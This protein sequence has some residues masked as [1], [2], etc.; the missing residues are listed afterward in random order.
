MTEVL[1]RAKQNVNERMYERNKTPLQAKFDAMSP[2]Q[3]ENAQWLITSALDQQ[4]PYSLDKIKYDN[5]NIRTNWSEYDESWYEEV[6]DGIYNTAIVGTAN[7]LYNLIPTV[8]QAVGVESKFLEDWQNQGD[9]FFDSWNAT[10]SDTPGFGYHL[11]AGIGFLLPLFMS[12][13]SSAATGIGRFGMAGL[14]QS[15]KLG[16]VGRVAL[17][18]AR[19]NSFLTGTTLMY[20]DLR[21]EAV[22]AGM[23][24]NNASRLALFTSGIVSMTEGAALEWIGQSVSAPVMK[25]I[26]KDAMMSTIKTLGEKGVNAQT[27]K[28]YQR[29]IQ[30]GFLNGMKRAGGNIFKG[31]AIEF[32][33]E[34]SQ[35]YIEE[36][37]KRAYVDMN[38]ALGGDLEE[39]MMGEWKDFAGTEGW[40]MFKEAAYSGSIGAIIGGGMGFVGGIRNGDYKTQTAYGAVENNLNKPEKLEKMKNLIDKKVKDQTYTLEQGEKMKQ[41]LD[42]MR[43]VALQSKAIG[44]TDE[45]NVAK[46]QVYQ[47][48][49]INKD[50]RRDFKEREAQLKEVENPD[51]KAVE[52]YNRDLKQ[53]SQFQEIVAEDYGKIWEERKPATKSTAVFE[54]RMKRYSKIADMINNKEDYNSIQD[55][56]NKLKESKAEDLKAEAQEEVKTQEAKTTE[57]KSTETKPEEGK[58]Y[59]EIGKVDITHL[60]PK[61]QEG[62]NLTE[63]QLEADKL[64]LSKTENPERI[65]VLEKKIA[66]SEGVLKSFSEPK[67]ETQK[68]TKPSEETTKTTE[69]FAEQ[70]QPMEEGETEEGFN[71][72][73][74]IDPE[75]KQKLKDLGYTDQEI[76]SM[77]KGRLTDI[78]QNKE[79]AKSWRKRNAIDKSEKLEKEDNGDVNYYQDKNI[80]YT[81]KSDGTILRN[82]KVESDNTI[83]GATAKVTIEKE[84][85]TVEEKTIDGV[86]YV[87][88]E[89]G[90]VYV[91]HKP[92]K[93]KKETKKAIISQFETKGGRTESTVEYGESQPS[94]PSS[95]IDTSVEAMKELLE[96]D[97]SG[98]A[99]EQVRRFID[100]FNRINGTNVKAVS[101][102]SK[103]IEVEYNGNTYRIPIEGIKMGTKPIIIF[104]KDSVAEMY[105]VV[106]DSVAPIN[107]DRYSGI[108]PSVAINNYVDKK[109]KSKSEQNQEVRNVNTI[110]EVAESMRQ[111]KEVEQTELDFD[112]KAEESKVEE[113]KPKTEEEIAQE[114]KN[115]VDDYFE[116][117]SGIEDDQEEDDPLNSRFKNDTRYKDDKIMN[118]PIMAQ[119][120][121]DYFQKI[122]PGISVEIVNKIQDKYGVNALGA[123]TKEGI[124][125]TPNA[126]Q[127]TIAHEFAHAYMWAKGMNNPLI[128]QGLEM[129]KETPFFQEAQRLY[130]NLSVE[131]QAE[132]AL[133][134]MLAVNSLEKLK[135]KLNEN[136][137]LLGRIVAFA[138]RFWTSV[139]SFFTKNKSK[140]IIEVLTSDFLKPKDV[141]YSK[142]SSINKTKYQVDKTLK[143]QIIEDYNASVVKTMIHHTVNLKR[144]YN[145]KEV[146]Y[147]ALH[148]LAM[149]ADEHRRL[150]NGYLSELK[151]KSD[152]V[153]KRSQLS[154]RQLKVL[155]DYG[156]KS[157]SETLSGQ[158]RMVL[159]AQDFLRK[160][161][162][163]ATNTKYGEEYASLD[164]MLRNYTRLSA[165]EI[166]DVQEQD[167]ALMEEQGRDYIKGDKRLNPTVKNIIDSLV[168]SSG[169]P[170]NK[171]ELNQYLA[172]LSG[173]GLDSYGY[174]KLLQDE[175]KGGN[176]MAQSLMNVIESLPEIGY[177]MP[178]IR[179]FNSLAID[180]FNKNLITL[181]DGKVINSAPQLNKD[182]KI[183]QASKQALNRLE[184]ANINI[185]DSSNPIGSLYE[186]LLRPNGKQVMDLK[187]IANSTDPK[188]INAFKALMQQVFPDVTVTEHT[189]R[190]W[191]ELTS[192]NKADII[193]SRI[194]NAYQP[195][196]KADIQQRHFDSYLALNAGYD[197]I[198]AKF[199]ATNGSNQM[200]TRYGAFMD[201]FNA[202]FL[203]NADFRKRIENNPDLKGNYILE[204]Y[205]NIGHTHFHQLDGIDNDITGRVFDYT[206][207]SAIETVMR[208]FSYYTQSGNYIQSMGINGR[209]YTT[210]IKIPK[211]TK[212]E[213]AKHYDAQ[214]KID[215]RIFEKALNKLKGESQEKLIKH[216]EKE[217]STISLSE[218]EI[219]KKQD[220]SV[221]VKITPPI[222]NVN[223][224]LITEDWWS[225]KYKSIA[226][227]F[228]NNKGEFNQEYL[229]VGMFKP[230]KIGEATIT[231]RDQ[232]F[233]NFILNDHIAR[234]QIANIYTGAVSHK[235]AIGKT[236]AEQIK[237][238]GGFNSNGFMEE[239]DRP[240]KF[241]VFDIGTINR[242]G[243]THDEK[244]KMI[245]ASDS[246]SIDGLRLFARKL[247]NHGALGGLGKNQKDLIYQ[248]NP[249]TN[250]QLYVKMST[251][252]AQELHLMDKPG[253]NGMIKEGSFVGY[254]NIQEM[255]N[256][257]DQYYAN[258]PG[259][260]YVKFID[261]STIKGQDLANAEVINLSDEAYWPGGKFDEQALISKVDSQ[262]TTRDIFNYSTAFDINVDY[263]AKQ[264]PVDKQVAT[265]STQLMSIA[266]EGMSNEQVLEFQNAILEKLKEQMMQNEEGQ[267]AVIQALLQD[268]KLVNKVMANAIESQ[269]DTIANLTKTILDSIKKGE[270]FD[271]Y[272]HPQLKGLIEST[273]LSQMSKKAFKIKLKGSYLHAIPDYGRNLKGY[274]TT[275]DSKR[276][277]DGTIHFDDMPTVAIPW[278]VVANSREEAEAMLK[279]ANA[280]QP[281]GD[282]YGLRVTNV[283]VPA[284]KEMSTFVARVEYFTDGEANTIVIPQDFIDASDSDHDGDKL[285]LYREPMVKT[286]TGFQRDH[287]SIDGKIWKSLHDMVGDQNKVN[288]FNTTDLDFGKVIGESIEYVKTVHGENNTV[289]SDISDNYSSNDYGARLSF[290]SRAIGILALTGKLHN[291]LLRNKVGLKSAF[292]IK[293]KAKEGSEFT[294]KEIQIGNIKPDTDNAIALNLQAALDAVKDPK[295]VESG[296]TQETIGV[297]RTMLMH[298]VSLNDTLAFIN[299][300]LITGAI[301][302]A[303]NETNAYTGS[304][305][306]YI[307]VLTEKINDITGGSNPEIN[308]EDLET[309]IK[310]AD[311]QN[312]GGTTTWITGN[313]L[314]VNSE[315]RTKGDGKV[316]REPFTYKVLN[317]T[318]LGNGKFQYEIQAVKLDEEGYNSKAFIKSYLKLNRLSQQYDKVL[319]LVRLDKGI[320]NNQEQIL[321]IE[322][323][324]SWIRKSSTDQNAL[325]NASSLLQEPI[326]KWHTEMLK[327]TKSILANKLFSWRND[328][329]GLVDQYN[330]DNDTQMKLN[331]AAEIVTTALAQKRI[332]S[333]SFKLDPD[334]Q[335]KNLINQISFLEELIWNNNNE[336]I[337]ATI[338]PESISNDI[339]KKE[340][341][342]VMNFFESNKENIADID[343]MFKMADPNTQKDI[344][345]LS[346]H[347]GNNK[348]NLWRALLDHKMKLDNVVENSELADNSFINS[349][350]VFENQ[351]KVKTIKPKETFLSA[352]EMTKKK[353]REDFAKLKKS[354]PHLADALVS[355][356][357]MRFGA[358]DKRGSLKE[359]FDTDM[360]M[361][362]LKD[363]KNDLLEYLSVPALAKIHWNV[364]N[365]QMK[366]GIYKQN[367]NYKSSTLMYLNMN[368]KTDSRLDQE[369]EDTIKRCK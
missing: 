213:M 101:I 112:Q 175:A 298:G 173:R 170:I 143:T 113:P 162:P 66:Q 271:G 253:A 106:T 158:E 124:Q 167:D 338:Y 326:S 34:F 277:S 20:N 57:T 316:I 244:G 278:S 130:P 84:L 157:K 6:M 194:F 336:D 238:A 202:L 151:F 77:D 225:K 232:I 354:H 296:I 31:G 8:A 49:S 351:D 302:Q 211:L 25:Q 81:R 18:N 134:Q 342:N 308:I 67:A 129:V 264:K 12:G 208:D 349:L 16:N 251:L 330:K 243:Q 50:I 44:L 33:Q 200:S 47:M 61:Q 27:M 138:K 71:V 164:M 274:K 267:S 248:V 304:K 240:V 192:K 196:Q 96:S 32:G 94:S 236:A 110:N 365:M 228:K 80:K 180:E 272:D 184:N 43:D 359:M 197:N 166:A 369:T 79:S 46:F 207:Q 99:Q 215:K 89:D 74:D 320:P 100:K 48:Q 88:T 252:A 23:D 165:D 178:I 37:M 93:Y 82:G 275:G 341:D 307:E 212:V 363:I 75:N 260:P 15:G 28:L 239:L 123:I 364:S 146:A 285:F 72:G 7:G 301:K 284:S 54:K 156:F 209:D 227:N 17:G 366:E 125:L 198:A 53:A 317:R 58:V 186:L 346:I 163:K 247:M 219:T 241:I 14:A 179:Q 299:D 249:D 4:D 292:K 356:N 345:Q 39:G 19:A 291:A 145:P 87:Q 237:R 40:N 126:F 63:K 1:S 230:I 344:G 203:N 26:S 147:K 201:R 115:A 119:K 137:S 324:I 109:N 269:N 348:N 343:S 321:Q 177:G 339:K 2:E 45:D 258:Q 153:T 352:P 190:E 107:N 141:Y 52:L 168:D 121:I 135:G 41:T 29:G 64:E 335:E 85:G 139:K 60:S 262:D 337:D 103:S 309:L 226:D 306:S 222:S 265:L 73:K 160:L 144:D 218:I 286:E 122:F 319:S 91:N 68:A 30:G 131:E 97:T 282:K 42:D 216:I 128:K 268:E 322:K 90:T 313:I 65:S 234:Q 172:G 233:E 323:N 297:A 266:Q 205:K 295:I 314:A 281:N 105:R 256:A 108:D 257:V 104:D 332:P 312:T 55:E 183:K 117:D 169:Y 76:K 280:K 273:I 305:K 21:K 95:A 362:L 114:L 59:S 221:N 242:K 254:A 293:V 283:R 229:N 328:F 136:K 235:L 36:A 193:P 171:S 118:D 327:E 24:P 350:T 231:D 161:K 140:D 13:G 290:S 83:G 333:T 206:D 361:N 150:G 289:K 288:A 276:N 358:T 78:I 155:S 9:K 325:F 220:G 270:S 210:G 250:E 204:H 360:D 329:I 224:K 142:G 152:G 127:S 120:I 368:P 331:R 315:Y 182:N 261:S 246:F 287:T 340:W 62:F 279:D 69:E 38:R 353:V 132:E 116:E 223:G 357:L 300:P 303:R 56:I 149:K 98:T 191:M 245:S 214:A 255:V 22:Q 310:T 86:K 355:Y 11:G 176:P 217:Y 347:F 10:T 174:L 51:P 195:G 199:I 263:S 35:T 5:P 154:E 311:V 159:N 148:D 70:F 187:E 3:K 92:G 111:P 133:A 189:L 367:G 181:K 334:T 185:N 318:D 102:D 294:L 259:S 188:H